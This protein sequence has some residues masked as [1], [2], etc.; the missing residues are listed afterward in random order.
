MST[1]AAS[2]LALRKGNSNSDKNAYDKTKHD[3]HYT[4]LFSIR[5]NNEKDGGER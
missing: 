5:Q 1:E 2:L 4:R 3:L